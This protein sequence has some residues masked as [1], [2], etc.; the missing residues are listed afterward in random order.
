MTRTCR[1]EDCGRVLPPRQGRGQE[2]STC[3]SRRR[4]VVALYIGPCTGCGDR[5]A[6]TRSGLCYRCYEA[7]RHRRR[8]LRLALSDL[9]IEE[10]F[11]YVRDALN[12]AEPGSEA[13]EKARKAAVAL[14]GALED[15]RLALYRVKRP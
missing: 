9:G 4:G 3:K 2:C 1:N 13:A 7:V 10:P 15:G 14:L 8:R 6:R 12:L 11:S 5:P